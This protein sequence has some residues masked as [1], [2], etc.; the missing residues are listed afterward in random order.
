[1]NLVDNPMLVLLVGG[2]DLPVVKLWKAR[3]NS[4][5]KLYPGGVSP[6]SRM[7][8]LWIEEERSDT[9]PWDKCTLSL[10]VFISCLHWWLMFAHSHWTCH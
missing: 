5:L 6:K 10:M 2:R 9:K 1:M 3:L 7:A 8:F 4:E